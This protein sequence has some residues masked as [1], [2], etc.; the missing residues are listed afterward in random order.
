MEKENATMKKI[1]ALL[2]TLMMLLSFAA[3][4]KTETPEVMSET[5][6]FTF[7]AVD[8]EGKETN[9]QISTDKKTVGEALIEEGLIAGEPGPYGLYVKTGNG[10]TLDYDKDGKYWAFYA[11]GEYGITGV[12]ETDIVPGSTYMFKPE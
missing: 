10:I 3:C 7:V 6:E 1:I 2:L 8:L 11:D 5:K 4:G 12:D 9:F